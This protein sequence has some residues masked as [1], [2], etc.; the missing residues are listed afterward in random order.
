MRKMHV[1]TFVQL[2][3]LET[4]EA[5]CRHAPFNHF[6]APPLTF[7]VEPKPKTDPSVRIETFKAVLFQKQLFFFQALQMT[8]FTAHLQA[9]RKLVC[10]AKYFCRVER[11]GVWSI[12]TRIFPEVGGQP[13]FS[14]YFIA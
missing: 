6:A 8:L 13:P 7:E 1:S 4:D 14:W 3:S 5:A 11:L 9:S 10:S 2:S 12:F